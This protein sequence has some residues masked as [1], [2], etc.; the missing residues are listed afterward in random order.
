MNKNEEDVCQK[1]RREE[2]ME[3]LGAGCKVMAWG[4]KD[5]IHLIQDGE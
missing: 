2:Q 4:D 5:W 3:D 1:V